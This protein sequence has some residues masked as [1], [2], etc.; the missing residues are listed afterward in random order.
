MIFVHFNIHLAIDSIHFKM[1]FSSNSFQLSLTDVWCCTFSYTRRRS[2]KFYWS[3]RTRG[4]LC[5]KSSFQGTLFCMRA[6]GKWFR[7]TVCLCR[8]SR[9][10]RCSSLRVGS[11]RT[12]TVWVG[13]SIGRGCL[14]IFYGSFELEKDRLVD[15]EVSWLDAEGLGFTLCKLNLSSRLWPSHF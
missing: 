11:H 13:R 10:R 3:R 15:K 1:I 2:R 12:R 14:R 6:A 5:A 9:L 4:C 8:R 7:A